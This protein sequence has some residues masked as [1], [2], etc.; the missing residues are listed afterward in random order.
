M[1]DRSVRNLANLQTNGSST[2][3][4]NLIAIWKAN[5]NEDGYRNN[6]LFQNYVLNRSIIVKHRLRAHESDF[7]PHG[8]FVAT[9]VILPM[10]VHDLKSG[11]RSF[12]VGETNY[13]E[14]LAELSV[15]DG[16]PDDLLLQLLDSIPSLDPFLLRERLM[17][18][19]FNPDPCYFELADADLRRMTDFARREVEPLVGVSFGAGSSRMN[20]KAHKLAAKL[21]GDVSDNELAPLRDSMGMN[22]ADFME[23]MFCWKGFIYY[24][25]QLAEILAEIGPI[26]TEMARLKP[27][28]TLSVDETAYVRQSQARLTRAINLACETVQK[29]LRVYD[30]AYQELTLK[31]R[32]QSFRAFL[33][34]APEMFHELGERLGALQHIMSFW[35]FRFPIGVNRSI[36]LDEMI[37]M[38]NDFEVSVTFESDRARSAA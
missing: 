14:C 28:G 24:K 1:V 35:R 37:D 2:R 3:T 38:L 7:F 10:D 21:L 12:F 27:V 36:S 4:L 11:A 15:R 26:I 20:E 5:R 8:V 19:G 17:A 13:A 31:G 22:Q 18:G 29:S 16:D 23:G 30:D 34:S 6:P 32:P 33:L 25:W 9:K